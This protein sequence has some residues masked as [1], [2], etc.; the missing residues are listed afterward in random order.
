MIQKVPLNQAGAD[1]TG[2]GTFFYEGQ[3]VVSVPMGGLLLFPGNEYH[4]GVPITS[5][6]RYLLVGF[7]RKPEAARKRVV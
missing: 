6:T 2:G 7:S 3:C 1:F 5:G 4:A